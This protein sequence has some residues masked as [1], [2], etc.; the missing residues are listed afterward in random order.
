[1]EKISGE[2]KSADVSA[3]TNGKKKKLTEIF[4]KYVQENIFN[5][6]ETAFF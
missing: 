2:E 4:K 1:M 6:D 3:Y 5:G